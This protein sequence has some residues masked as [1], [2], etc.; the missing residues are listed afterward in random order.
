MTNPEP[1]TGSV[2]RFLASPTVRAAIVR[3]LDGCGT[4]REYLT[5]ALLREL[6]ELTPSGDPETGLEV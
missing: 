1:V 3:T 4:D 5:D 2:E 6:G